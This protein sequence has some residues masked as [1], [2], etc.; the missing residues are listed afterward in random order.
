[1]KNYPQLLQQ[2][3]QLRAP[4]LEPG[5]TETVYWGGGTPF[6]LPA[7]ALQQAVDLFTP[8]L[9]RG[10]VEWSV[11]G[12]PASITAAKARLLAGAGVNRVTLGVQ[13]LSGPVTAAVRREED[14]A[15]L[16]RAVTLLRSAGITNIGV[17]LI[18]GLPGETSSGFAAG[19][20]RV[21]DLDI[22]HLS[23]YFL[24]LEPGAEWYQ[25]Y[26]QGTLNPA[27]DWLM[28]RM[29]NALYRILRR[30]GWEQ[31]E[32]SNF[33]RPGYQS[34]HNRL[35]WQYATL[36]GLGAA[37]AGYD[38]SRRWQNPRSLNRYRSLVSGGD[39]V[40]FEYEQLSSADRFNE[41]L[42]L[43]LRTTDGVD[44]C[45]VSQLSGLPA[46]Q[47]VGEKL[48]GFVRQGWLRRCGS[49]FYPTRS[50]FLWLDQMLAACFI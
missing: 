38:G 29:Y 39:A 46:E 3:L 27:P 41:A 21:L 40:R 20:A 2:E 8:A 15:L 4:H 28:L 17:D 25:S 33:C 30:H 18:I 16:E 23:A 47:L 14:A 26:L 7:S 45:A 44:L 12:T 19:V 50:G 1:M 10:L 32:V 49:F 43:G 48:G 9:R 37:A 13:S 31:Y 34:R 22:T 11:E 35:T 5:I 36:L 24:R 6:L 42:L